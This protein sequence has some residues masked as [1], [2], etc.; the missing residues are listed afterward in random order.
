MKKLFFLVTICSSFFFHTLKAS[1]VHLTDPPNQNE[2]I[3]VKVLWIVL[4]LDEIKD[5]DQ[6]FAANIFLRLEWHDKRLVDTLPNAKRRR[7]PVGEVWHP[8][9][10]F[11]DLQKWWGKYPKTVEV[12]PDGNVVFLQKVW[13]YFSQPLDLHNFPFDHQLLNISV[14]PTGFA[15]EKIRLVLDPS[16]PSGINDNPSIVDWEIEGTNISF[17]K[18]NI[19]KGVKDYNIPRSTF[20]ISVKRKTGYYILKILIPLVLIVAMSMII[21][22]VPL[23][24]T[25]TRLSISISS[26]LTS[27]SSKSSDL[28]SI[29]FIM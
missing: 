24:D 3:E 25:S 4:D 28:L 1:N 16:K 23:K 26:M 2:P 20:E 29:T 10:E 14:I 27:S 19:Y 17:D 9:I 11:T 12:T 5:A 7:L 8:N 22:F 15:T 18:L 6:S 13:G 21:F